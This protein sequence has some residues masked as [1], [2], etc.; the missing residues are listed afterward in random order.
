M[1]NH[2]RMHRFT[3]A[4]NR[5]LMYAYFSYV[6]APPR[7]KKIFILFHI[8]REKPNRIRLLLCEND[9]DDLRPSFCFWATMPHNQDK[10]LL[11]S[12]LKRVRAILM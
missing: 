7:V 3:R 2:I 12:N 10:P 6:Y 1:H 8:Y 11:K 9:R 5:S 4:D